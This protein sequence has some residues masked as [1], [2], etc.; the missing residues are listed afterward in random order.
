MS[1]LVLY[2]DGKCPLC[3]KEMGHLRRHDKSGKLLLIDVHSERFQS[4][5]SVTIEEAMLILHA[6][7]HQGTLYLGLDAAHKAWSLLGKRRLYGPL[8][9]PLIKPIA[10]H[11]YV[12]FAKNRYR[13]SARLLGKASC[14]SGRCYKR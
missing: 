7:D 1:E 3:S 6:I 13:L 5:N 12:W 14:D 11:L 9:L 8:R 10:D 2:Y 4:Q